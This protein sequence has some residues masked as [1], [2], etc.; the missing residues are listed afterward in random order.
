[1]MMR[2]FRCERVGCVAGRTHDLRRC[3]PTTEDV[4]A[5]V[6]VLKIGRVTPLDLSLLCLQMSQ[7]KIADEPDM[8]TE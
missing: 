5:V 2:P 8:N 6:G 3:K 7:T 4:A 1:M